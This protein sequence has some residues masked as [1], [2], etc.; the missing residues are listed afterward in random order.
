MRIDNNNP[1][2]IDNKFN[3]GNVH[4][5]NLVSNKLEIP[6]LNN[7]KPFTSDNTASYYDFYNNFGSMLND[8][9]F[10]GN[11][12]IAR[13]TEQYFTLKENLMGSNTLNKTNQLAALEKAYQ[14]SV[15]SKATALSNHLKSIGFSH[16]RKVYND[17]RRLHNKAGSKTIDD[18]RSKIIQMFKM[19]K[20]HYLKHGSLKNLPESYDNIKFE[21][22][23]KIS[24]VV[25]DINNYISKR[26]YGLKN[27][28]LLKH[29]ITSKVQNYDF[30]E[31]LSNVFTFILDK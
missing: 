29:E 18:F 25:K 5:D 23:S 6:Q 8:A 13:F 4:K 24:G 10:N 12:N 7:V 22:L 1:N 21:D 27:E 11:Q 14:D 31:Y 16:S 19:A 9:Y 30:G 15:F 26:H 28:N 2:V 20:I 17:Y 3:Q